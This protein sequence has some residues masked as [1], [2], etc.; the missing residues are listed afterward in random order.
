MGRLRS[1]T[2]STAAM[3]STRRPSLWAGSLRRDHIRLEDLPSDTIHEGHQHNASRSG[4]SSASRQN[5]FAWPFH[6]RNASEVPSTSRSSRFTLRTWQ[7]RSFF[8]PHD[9]AASIDRS[10]V[11][12]YVVNFMR[13]ETPETLARKREQSKW[14]QHG[15]EVT[16]RRGTYASYPVEF[17]NYASPETEARDLNTRSSWSRRSGLRRHITG[18][19]GG[20]IFNSL[21]SCVILLV[22][23]ICLILVIT[24]TKLLSGESAIFSGDCAKANHINTG[25]HLV[26]NIFGVALVSGANYV[27]Q[28]LSSPTRREVTV[29]HENKHW[30]DIGIPSIRNFTHISGFRGT[31]AI[32]VLL[33]AVA[34][35][36]M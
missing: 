27:F 25:V 17:G 29:A 15:V 16:P 9:D 8:R 31:V 4:P 21:V 20:V 13:G 23:I 6:G 5:S 10:I 3:E 36:V 7:P 11:P 24:K 35:Q 12:D 28:V 19:R 33:G 32:L 14:G 22:G 18:W 26:I 1:D 2:H 30:L 34:T